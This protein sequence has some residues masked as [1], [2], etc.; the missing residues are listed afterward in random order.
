MQ[1]RLEKRAQGLVLLAALALSLLCA[2]LI[3]FTW[4]GLRRQRDLL[5]EHVSLTSRVIMR[6]MQANLLRAVRRGHDSFR[7]DGFRHN[8]QRP[9]RS[10]RRHGMP[11]RRQD[12]P[13]PGRDLPVPDGAFPDALFS[14][15][16]RDGNVQFMAVAASDG[17]LLFSFPDQTSEASDD[18]SSADSGGLPHLSPKIM[19]VLRRNGEWSA[20]VRW[21]GHD[22]LMTGMRAHPLLARLCQ[23]ARCTPRGRHGGGKQ[24]D[25]FFIVGMGLGPY[26][27]QYDNFRQGALLQ[28]SFVIAGAALCMLLITAYIKRRE[29]GRRL[30]SLEEVH[31]TLLDAMPDGLLS[32]DEDG[33]I[34]AANRSAREILAENDL[35]GRPW[36]T[37]G[38]AMD[39]E[40]ETEG[41]AQFDHRGRKLE[42][43]LR[44]LDDPETPGRLV[45]V[46]DRTVFKRLEERLGNAE[47]LA[48]V[49]RMAAGAAHE[50]RNPLSS[51]RGFAQFFMTKFKGVAPE[52]EYAA[53]MVREAD[54]LNKV[55]TD[56]LFLAKPR[57]LEPVDVDLNAMA[58]EVAQILE[59][60][61]RGKGA[62]FESELGI[63]AVHADA[64]ALKQALINL[65]VN[66]LGAV[67]RDAG[68]VVMISGVEDGAAWVGVR[69]NGPGMSAK[70]A[71]QALEPFYTT[72]KDGTGLGLA[73]VDTIMRE[74][75]GRVD[76]SGGPGQGATVRLIF[77]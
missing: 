31:V 47:K 77:G 1:I 69:D 16:A 43:L 58:A 12:M 26:L 36:S 10:G 34:R 63:D 67:E 4:D 76:I 71:Q 7:H 28:M 53:T 70:Q 51:L 49:G 44:E 32:L 38:P 66:S 60:D 30:A 68:H 57:S 64:D 50:I 29:E 39:A 24:N 9:D 59:P 6:G 65:V 18:S 35:V 45:L 54:R 48:A 74:H 75:H 56:M 55:I 37:L 20:P 27:E 41:W 11:D 3:F 8:G 52:E 22:V 19:E 33:V 15:L 42:I 23:D 21:H 17:T 61:I 14:T 62:R 2:S 46:R 73:I 25:V 40:H 72:R 5:N 13:G